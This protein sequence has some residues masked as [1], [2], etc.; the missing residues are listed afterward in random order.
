MDGQ[1]GAG[2]Q[3]P[4]E[5]NDGQLGGV[6]LNSERW[7]VW[8][9]RFTELPTT[10]QD[11]WQV[12]GPEIHGPNVSPF[13]QAL[14]MLEVGPDKHR[15][16]NANA[17]RASTRYRDIGPIELGRTYAMK[18]HVR[19]SAGS[20]GI[21]EIWR[22][23]VKVV[24]LPGATIFQATSGS[25]WKEANYRNASIN[26]V[27]SHDFSSLR[28]Y[29]GDVAFG[30][31][32][33]PPPPPPRPRRTRPRPRRPPRRRFRRSGRPCPRGT[34]QANPVFANALTGLGL[35]AGQRHGGHGLRRQPGRHGEPRQ[36]HD[37]H[38]R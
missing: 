30:S 37:V 4:S 14:L 32:G 10:S 6:P 9:E 22:D 31:G 35:L 12:V 15:R 11:R 26:G 1:T 25:Y 24:D 29:D 33:T 28:I 2:A 13:D 3:M 5:R 36:R 16:L 27:M 38:P 7:V 8:Y 19:L 18:M 23:G 17:G 34:V 20:D 21:I